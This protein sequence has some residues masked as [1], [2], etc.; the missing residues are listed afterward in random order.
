LHDNNYL[1]NAIDAPV[2]SSTSIGT[3]PKQAQDP[4]RGEV[5]YL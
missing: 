1:Y 5:E 4:F 2:L 3:N